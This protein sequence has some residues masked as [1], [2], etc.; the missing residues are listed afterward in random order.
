MIVV[1]Y[2]LISFAP[3]AGTSVEQGLSTLLAYP[4]DGV[5]EDDIVETLVVEEET[6]AYSH[7]KVGGERIVPTHSVSASAPTDIDY[8]RISREQLGMIAI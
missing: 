8:G 7:I 2:F 4:A 6:S 1:L 5:P 3:C